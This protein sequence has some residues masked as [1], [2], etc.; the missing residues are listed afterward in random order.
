[1]KIY[2]KTGDTGQTDLIGERVDKD[3]LTISVIGTLD[4]LNSLFGMARSKCQ[5][6]NVC[7]AVK[8]LQGAIFTISAVIAGSGKNTLKIPSA[9]NLEEVIDEIEKTL[10]P[11]ENFIL[12][13]GHETAATLHHARSVCRRA[14]RLVVALHKK[15]PVDK[16]ILEFVNR[17]SDFLFV[18]ARY[19]NN[20]YMLNE[21][22]WEG[23][24]ERATQSAMEP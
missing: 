8:Y 16:G 3:N 1:M 17:T 10:P 9:K 15:A 21:T 12:P 11:L 22:I 6:Q 4:E 2:T 13:G 20:Y 18:M 5:L 14:E 24:S 23:K 19:V 7:E